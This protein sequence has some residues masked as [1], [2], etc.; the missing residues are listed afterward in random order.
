[1]VAMFVFF[2]IVVLALLLYCNHLMDILLEER[3]L[4]MGI[5]PSDEE[6]T[7]LPEES[8]QNTGNGKCTTTC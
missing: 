3:R 2:M 6:C 1:M 8:N 4:R 5:D 7:A